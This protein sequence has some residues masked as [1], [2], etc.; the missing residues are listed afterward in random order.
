MGNI[1][2]SSAEKEWKR[3]TKKNTKANRDVIATGPDGDLGNQDMI[4]PQIGQQQR[5]L[6]S[7]NIRFG[8]MVTEVTY[9]HEEGEIEVAQEN[10]CLSYD[11]DPHD[12]GL[13]SPQVVD[14]SNLSIG[15][16]GSQKNLT[17]LSSGS[18]LKRQVSTTAGTLLKAAN[19]NDRA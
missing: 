2:S 1:F 11:D 19:A 14:S 6:S 4:P 12:D 17:R 5:Q 10:L 13:S 16:Q 15:S 18:I 3:L 8:N 7:G 9:D